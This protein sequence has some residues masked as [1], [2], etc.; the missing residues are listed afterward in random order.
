MDLVG[1]F[2]MQATA[3][4]CRERKKRCGLIATLKLVLGFLTQVRWLLQ[5]FFFNLIISSAR[6][7]LSSVLL[8][9][10]INPLFPPFSCSSCSLTRW[11]RRRLCGS[12]RRGRFQGLI[13]LLLGCLVFAALCLVLL[14][15]KDGFY[16]CP[17]IFL[18]S[19]TLGC[20]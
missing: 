1:L 6:I 17:R 9:R 4:D 18:L 5:F 2:A 16:L 3:R 19:R 15:A 14:G 11:I 7:E 8:R 12:A 10:N 13:N 20:G